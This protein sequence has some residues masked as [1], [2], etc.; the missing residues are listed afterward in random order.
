MRLV[1]AAGSGVRGRPSGLAELP[2]QRR[3]LPPQLGQLRQDLAHILPAPLPSVTALLPAVTPAAA[4]VFLLWR[5]ILLSKWCVPP[6]RLRKHT[7]K[8]SGRLW[9]GAASLVCPDVHFSVPAVVACV[10]QIRT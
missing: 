10:A 7:L 2:A 9:Q 6:G 8:A 5:S 4:A 1:G 3:T